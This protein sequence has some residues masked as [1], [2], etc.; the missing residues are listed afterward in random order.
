M[1]GDP[2]RERLRRALLRHAPNASAAE[3]TSAERA[4]GRAVFEALGRHARRAAGGARTDTSAPPVGTQSAAPDPAPSASARAL[5]LDPP[6]DLVRSERGTLARTVSFART[7]RHGHENLENV[8]DV[9]LDSLAERARDERLAEVDLSRA[10]FFDTETTGL[11]G[12]AGTYVFL[13]GL[14]GF[15]DEQFELW[16][17]FLPHPADERL[18]LLEVAERIAGASVLVS[19][20]GKS[21]DRHRLEDKMRLHGVTP[22]FESVVHLDLYHPLRRAHRGRFADCRLKTLEREVGGFA[23]H[24]DLPGSFAPAAWFD[25]LARRPHALEGVFRHNRDDVLSLAT[26]LCQLAR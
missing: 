4:A 22:P 17:G 10:L 26:L 1:S 6:R 25:F 21:F 9:R 19:F 13:V 8:F 14:L 24:D 12:G 7:H 16:Q 11:S 23:R 3:P 18:L 20:F 2:I 5:T 15:H